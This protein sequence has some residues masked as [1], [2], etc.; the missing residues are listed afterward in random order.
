MNPTI[1]NI[2]RNNGIA[3]QYSYKVVI[4]YIDENPS[5][6]E[7]VGNTYGGPIVFITESGRQV[8]VNNPE[9]FGS[10]LNKSWITRFFS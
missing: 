1:L 6:V 5:T 3:G 8:F 2:K 4:Q 10:Q 9:R 7:F